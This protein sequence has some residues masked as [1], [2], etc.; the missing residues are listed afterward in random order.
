VTIG[1]VVVGALLSG[2]PVLAAR[3]RARL[4]ALDAHSAAIVELAAALSMD[5]VTLRT[6]GMLG[7]PKEILDYI[8]P[9]LTAAAGLFIRFDGLGDRAS[10]KAATDFSRATAAVLPAALN[11][12][13]DM[14]VAV[15]AISDAASAVR[16]AVVA[17]RLRW[18]P[19][20]RW[21]RTRRQNRRA[22][23]E[24]MADAG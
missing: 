6:F 7:S 18:H 11:S 16:A 8:S 4:D 20:R 13:E 1:A 3:R 12:P 17:A 21:R 2:I 22:A 10:A 19:I 15:V 24:A 5:L 14:A 9:R 23:E